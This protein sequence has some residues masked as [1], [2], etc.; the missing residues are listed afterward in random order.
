ML[1][2]WLSK[3]K[4]IKKTNINFIF[5]FFIFLE[6]QLKIPSITGSYLTRR[7]VKYAKSRFNFAAKIKFHTL[8][9]NSATSF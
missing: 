7:S 9:F 1:L 3:Y 6:T 5:V 4:N 8:M 2:C